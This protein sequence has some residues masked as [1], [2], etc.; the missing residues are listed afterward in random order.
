[1]KQKL[2]LSCA[3]VHRPDI[4]FLDEP[5]TG[6]DAVSRR[7]F[8]DLL[9]GLRASGLP[10]VVSTPYMDEADR[11][12]RVALM[13]RGRVLAI[14]RPA[15]VGDRFPYP[16]VAVRPRAGVD[17]HALIQALRALP[18]AAS[19]WPFGEELHYGDARA[20]LAPER[21]AVELRAALAAL[22]PDG[23]VADVVPIR[24]GIEDAFMALM[25]APD[26]TGTTGGT[27][28]GAAA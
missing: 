14:D 20:A 13:A 7:E 5:T 27:P 25:G 12:D 18:H 4:L 28:A 23:A 8:W 22:H 15:A 6:V 16:L 3:L 10:I 19:V 24:P 2:A 21:V 1:M 26:A 9:A 11:C 17:R